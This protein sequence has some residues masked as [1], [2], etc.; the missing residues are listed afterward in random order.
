[1]KKAHALAEKAA[2]AK[3]REAALFE[4]YGLKPPQ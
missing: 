2:V 1:L 4:K 3:K